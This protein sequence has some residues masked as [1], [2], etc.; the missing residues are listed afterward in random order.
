MSERGGGLLHSENSVVFRLIQRQYCTS[1]TTSPLSRQ[2][3]FE[4]AQRPP[5]NFC[6]T[7][8]VAYGSEILILATFFSLSGCVRRIL[9]NESKYRDVMCTPTTLPPQRNTPRWEHMRQ[10]ES[11]TTLCSF[12]REAQTELVLLSESSNRCL[13][14][15]Q[16]P[17]MHERA[18][19]L[20]EVRS[21][22]CRCV[23]LSVSL[24]L[25]LSFLLAK[26]THRGLGQGL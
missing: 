1:M 8:V 14:T 13:C 16:A 25:C 11:L 20:V 17:I 18:E 24:S 6:W 10:I 26:H 9:M 23:W 15:R 19:K 21:G 22:A 12:M 2:R 3:V 7:F 5:K 4:C